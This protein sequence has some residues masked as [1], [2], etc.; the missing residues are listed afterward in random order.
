MNEINVNKELSVVVIPDTV[1]LHKTNMNLKIDKKT[2]S[3]LYNRVARDDFYGIAVAVKEIEDES[4]YIDEDL[5]KTGT[6]IKINKVK[7]H[8][9]FYHINV[10]I[11]ERAKIEEFIPDGRNY[12]ATYNLIPDITDLDPQK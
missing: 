6:L 2:G 8:K 4:L 5:Y 11:I 12:R 10:E 7:Q 9:H 3:E 1:L